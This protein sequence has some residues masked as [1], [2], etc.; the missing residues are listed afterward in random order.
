MK[1]RPLKKAIFEGLV[2]DLN[3]QPVSVTYVGDEPVM[4]STMT[5]L[6]V[7]SQLKRLTAKSGKR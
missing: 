7:M 1:G 2:Y 3:S 4:L 5:A 6:C